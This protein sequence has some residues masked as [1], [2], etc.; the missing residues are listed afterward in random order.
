MS[1][2]DYCAGSEKPA[3]TPIEILYLDP[4]NTLEYVE[5]TAELI[6]RVKYPNVEVTVASLKLPLLIKLTGLEWRAFENAIWFPVA[7]IVHYVAD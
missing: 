4:A 2:K 6:V 5:I 1:T 7:Y 3:T